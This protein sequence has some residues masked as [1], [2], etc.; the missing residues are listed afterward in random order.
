[1]KVFLGIVAVL[2]ILALHLWRHVHLAPES[3]GHAE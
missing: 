1:M 2:V 3:D